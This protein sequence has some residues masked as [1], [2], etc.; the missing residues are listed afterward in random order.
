MTV[1]FEKRDVPVVSVSISVKAGGINETLE[2]K[3][4]SHYI[5]HMLY[6]GTP[7]RSAIDI[8]REIEKRGGELNGFTAETLTSFWCRMP[9]K[10]INV[11]LEVLGDMVK[12]PKFDSEELEK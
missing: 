12:N 8:S 5:E 10:H 6:K 7:T 1:L 3:G 9:S 11:A 2:E 4:I